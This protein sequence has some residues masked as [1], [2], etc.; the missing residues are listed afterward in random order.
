MTSVPAGASIRRRILRGFAVLL[1]ALAVLQAAWVAGETREEINE[2]HDMALTTAALAG[3]A[4]GLG[5]APAGMEHAKEYFAANVYFVTDANG[6]IALHSRG[7]KRNPAVRATGWFKNAP[8]G[9]SKVRAPNPAGRRKDFWDR[10]LARLSPAAGWRVHVL[11]LDD[12][13]RAVAAQSLAWRREILFRALFPGLAVI[14]LALPVLAAGLTLIIRRGFAPMERLAEDAASRRAGDFRP[15]DAA[16]APEE[17]RKFAGAFNEML[18]RIADTFRREKSF[19]ANAA[20]ELRT[21]LAAIRIHAEN[22]AAASD[23]DS[24]RRALDELLKAAAR[25]TGTTSQLL[26]LARAESESPPDDDGRRVSLAE[27]CRDAAAQCVSD[28]DPDSGASDKIAL[29]TDADAQVP[30]A[31]APLVLIVLRNLIGNALRH[32]GNARIVVGRENGAAV[33][34]VLDDGPGF[35]PE[36]SP[37]L[38]EPFERGEAGAGDDSGCGLGLSICAAA[39]ERIGAKLEIGNRRDGSGASARMVFGRA[40]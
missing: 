11:P 19:T 16:A 17:V 28:S 3:R 1:A 35:V 33:V 23:D 31:F 38:L 8:P 24:R 36:F 21:P 32:G 25:A 40:R 13:G 27:L 29:T 39:A 10:H 22:A 9:F 15:L 14:L 37:R 4:D 34:S 18:A 26:D 7:A 6:R 30:A 20:H 5:I 2:Y 12:G